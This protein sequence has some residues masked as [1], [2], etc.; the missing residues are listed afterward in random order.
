ML[1]RF[2]DSCARKRDTFH[3]SLR[4]EKS[5][6]YKGVWTLWWCLHQRFRSFRSCYRST[7][8][9]NNR[10]ATYCRRRASWCNFSPHEDFCE[11]HTLTHQ[12]SVK[13]PEWPASYCSTQNQQC[14]HVNTKPPPSINWCQ[15]S[16]CQ[17]WI[18][19][20]SGISL[21]S[22]LSPWQISRTCIPEALALSHVSASCNSFQTL[23]SAKFALWT[24]R[25]N[26][27]R[28]SKWSVLLALAV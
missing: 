18:L 1:F 9:R 21:K 16:Q 12:K 25:V 5:F 8:L 7:S 28:F 23:C 3:P 11:E 27:Q 20:S 22:L 13:I 10:Y 26:E 6:V 14:N 24:N 17:A 19:T 4:C 15:V 2:H